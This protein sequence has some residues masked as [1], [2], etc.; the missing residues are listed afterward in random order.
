MT[1]QPADVGTD[2]ITAFHKIAGRDLESARMPEI[3]EG[4]VVGFAP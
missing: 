1:C 4:E 2:L 3:G